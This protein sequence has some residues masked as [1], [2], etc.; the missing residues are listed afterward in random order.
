M[1]LFN[2]FFCF[3]NIIPFLSRDIE[4]FLSFLLLPILFSN[5]LSFWSLPFI[6]DFLTDLVTLDCL[7]LF[8]SEA[9]Y[10]LKK[11]KKQIYG[12]QREQRRRDELGIWD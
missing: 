8:K 7:L 6:L 1:L 9:L 11:N 10:T 4:G 5:C 3:L 12:Y 2:C